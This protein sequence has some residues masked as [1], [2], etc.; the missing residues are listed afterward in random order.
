M[1]GGSTSS[2]TEETSETAAQQSEATINI[3]SSD[4]VV[5]FSE[6]Q[7]NMGNLLDDSSVNCSENRSETIQ[8]LRTNEVALA[9]GMQYSNN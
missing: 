1:W 9:H 5:S 8:T 2:S 6:T 4:S 3:P 7:E